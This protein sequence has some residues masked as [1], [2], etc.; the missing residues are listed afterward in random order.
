MHIYSS[1]YS[2]SIRLA[3]TASSSTLGCV[4]GSPDVISV[5]RRALDC[6]RFI[7]MN[8]FAMPAMLSADFLGRG[9]DGG[10]AVDERDRERSMFG[11]CM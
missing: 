7:W 1:S 4:V 5:F 3:I 11:G 8:M 9:D 6:R 2:T 10:E